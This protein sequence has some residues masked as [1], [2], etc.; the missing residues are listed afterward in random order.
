MKLIVLL[1][2]ISYIGSLF[3][4]PIYAQNRSK[5]SYFDRAPYGT[6]GID[7]LLFYMEVASLKNKKNKRLFKAVQKSRLYSIRYHQYLDNVRER[8]VK[9]SGGAYTLEEALAK[10]SA[11]L[12][13]KPKGKK[14]RETPQ[15]IFITGDYDKK[16]KRKP[17]GPILAKKIKDL[18][19]FYQKTIL[20][21]WNKQ[22]IEGTIFEDITKKKAIAEEL[23]SRLFLVG[24]AT[25]EAE[26]HQ[27]KSWSEYTFEHLP[28][29]AIYPMLRKFQND[30]T[31]SEATLVYLL[32]SQMDDLKIPLV[33]K[34][35]RSPIYGALRYRSNESLLLKL[36]KSDHKL[37]YQKAQE[38]QELR[39]RFCE[40]IDTIRDRMYEESGGVYTPSEAEKLGEPRLV[41]RP[42]GKRNK[43]TPQRIFLTGDYGNS[44]KRAPEGRII[45]EK[46]NALKA[47]YIASVEALWTQEG[48][49]NTVFAKMDYKSHIIKELKEELVLTSDASW[50]AVEHDGKSW[51]VYVFEK[52]PVA[53]IAPMLR[54]FQN[55]ATY[56]EQCIL[57][58]L[59]SQVEN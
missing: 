30:A 29:A 52:M 50:E 28:V 33:Y 15:R 17:E 41:G 39:L 22:G 53:A 35:R 14:D 11:S 58:L 43:E 26:E 8:M 57:D 51:E 59:V 21:L 19:T 55:D 31:N 1:G 6:I 40:Y 18:R 45:A 7:S 23:P 10:G 38:I 42:K 36:E 44:D 12:E 5:V 2:I 46:I 37:L 25:Y 34:I 3:M 24:D 4:N 49:P 13:G 27:G 20:N 47:A 54:K 32:A 9:E 48:L 56:S 16:R